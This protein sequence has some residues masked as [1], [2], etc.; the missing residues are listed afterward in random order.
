MFGI[1][2]RTIAVLF[3]IGMLFS[4]QIVHA[5]RRAE[6]TNIR[7]KG[8]IEAIRP[9][10]LKVTAGGGA[11]VLKVQA[12]PENIALE[13]TADKDWLQPGMLVRFV[14]SLNDKGIA[15]TPVE[16]LSVFTPRPGY[17]VGV[18]REN[19]IDEHVGLGGDTQPTGPTYLVAGKLARIKDGQIMVAAGRDR[20]TAS[21]ADEVKI[22]VDMLGDYR[23]ARPGDEIEFR[24]RVLQ[25]GQAIIG[26]MKIVAANPFEA[27]QL[28]PQKKATR[29]KAATSKNDKDADKNS[30]DA[31]SGADG[32]VVEDGATTTAANR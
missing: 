5:Q 11:W 12:K 8:K 19:R 15:Q 20:V 21:L 22:T 27:P 25:P 7:S 14:A 16:E 13:G 26:K 24:G 10:F 30:A 31:A 4:S 28:Q 1:A 29:R 3:L 17:G 32:D 2:V 18:L 6:L 23:L 9:G